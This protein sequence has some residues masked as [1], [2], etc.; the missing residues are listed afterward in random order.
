MAPKMGPKLVQKLAIF[1]FIFGSLVFEVLELFGCLL[2][3]FMGLWSLSWEAPGPQKPRKTKGFLRFLQMQDFGSLRLLVALLG[4]SSPLLGPIWSQNGPQNGP[5]S[6]PKSAQK[7]VK[8]MDPKITPKMTVLG[9]KIAPKS[10][11]K[12]PTLLDG[13][14][15]GHPS[16]ARWPQDGP[17]M[18]QDAQDAPK[19]APRWP[20]IAPRW[21]KMP[22]D[23]PKMAPRCPEMAPR[24][25]QDGPKC[26]S[27][28]SPGDL[29]SF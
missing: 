18:A 3:A 14:N 1:G 29:P 22:Q 12:R 11:S 21:A 26:L 15:L 9:P 20:K 10:G 8:K 24:W 4:P 16:G 23:A 19:M 13:S 6:G 2:G 28:G 7:L 25:P 5:K 27:R 17:K